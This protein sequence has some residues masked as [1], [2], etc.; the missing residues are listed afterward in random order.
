MLHP[1]AGPGPFTPP[2]PTIPRSISTREAPRFAVRARG[3]ELIRLIR[4][5]SENL[6]TFV[7]F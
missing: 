1:P 6:F 5:D 3:C 2:V 7:S 4:N